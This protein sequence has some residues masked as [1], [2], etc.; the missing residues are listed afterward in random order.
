MMSALQ[1]RPDLKAEKVDITPEMSESEGRSDI[2][3]QQES[4]LMIA[5]DRRPST[6]RNGSE[7]GKEGATWERDLAIE[8]GWSPVPDG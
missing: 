6:E 8:G 3:V 7:S 1:A 4:G 5:R 2:K